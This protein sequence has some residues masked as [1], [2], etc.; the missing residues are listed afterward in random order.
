MTVVNAEVAEHGQ[1]GDEGDE[2]QQDPRGSTPGKSDDDCEPGQHEHPARGG[3]VHRYTIYSLHDMNPSPIDRTGHRVL[4]DSDFEALLEFRDGLRRFLRWSEEG[5]KAIGLTPAQHQLLLAVRG[6]RGPASVSEIAEHLL[7]R[8]HSAVE[9]VDRTAGAGLVERV[10]DRDDHRVV[11][12]VLTDKG[13]R[14]LSE[15]S[16]GHLEELSRIG[17]KLAALWHRL[18]DSQG[19]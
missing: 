8:H 11:R 18:P 9:L 1:G 5:A 14:M 17:P 2:V 7:L 4:D 15:L 3:L 13:E 19:S 16:A 12:V 10:G 6:H